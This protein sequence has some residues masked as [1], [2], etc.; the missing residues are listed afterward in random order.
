[1][2]ARLIERT[3]KSSPADEDAPESES[4]RKDVDRGEQRADDHDAVYLAVDRARKKCAQI[5]E[6]F[7]IDTLAVSESSAGTTIRTM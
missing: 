3:S 1:M 7:A 2:P 5:Q 6:S 4:E